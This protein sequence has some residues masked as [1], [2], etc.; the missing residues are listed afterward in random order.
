MIRTYPHDVIKKR[1]RE[2]YKDRWDVYECVINS[3]MLY[4]GKVRKEVLE[5][6]NEKFV[7]L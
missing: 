2:K 7:E 4:Y 1:C 3:L 6:R 5:K